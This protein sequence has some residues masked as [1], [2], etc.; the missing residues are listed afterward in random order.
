MQLC[1]QPAKSP[2]TFA[3]L[4]FPPASP[5]C[6]S[7]CAASS[8]FSLTRL[9]VCCPNCAACDCHWLDLANLNTQIQTGRFLPTFFI[10]RDDHGSIERIK[11]RCC[12]LYPFDHRLV[13][14]DCIEL[15]QYGLTVLFKNISVRLHIIPESIFY[16]M[17][18]IVLRTATETTYPFDWP[19]RRCRLWNIV[20]CF[21][22]FLKGRASWDFSSWP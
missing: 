11:N 2:S 17:Y 16:T 15:S 21:Y 14:A 19:N 9:L 8:T 6:S 3:S 12:F 20:C 10:G 1:C 4:K 5:P 22:D 13:G 7:L 18:P